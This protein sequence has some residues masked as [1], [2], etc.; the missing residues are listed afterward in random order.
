MEENNNKISSFQVGVIGFF[1][2]DAIFVGLG[3]PSMFSL[4]E[5]DAWI[6]SLLAFIIGIIPIVILMY[7]INYKPELNILEKNKVIFGKWV[8]SIVNILLCVYILFMAV[9]VLWNTTSFAISIYLVDTPSN[10]IAGMFV[11]AA[12]YAVI[13]GIETIGRTTEILFFM[14]VAII[15]TIVLS[16]YSHADMDN[17]KP[18]VAHGIMPVVKNTFIY[19]SY[20]FTPAIILTIIRKNSIVNKEH[21]RRYLIGGFILGLLLMVAVFVIIPAVI[22]PSLA[23]IYRF[24]AYYVQ[25]KISIGGAIN[26]VENFLSIHWLFSTFIMIVMGVYFLSEFVKNLFKVEKKKTM[27]LIIAGIG[28]LIVFLQNFIFKDSVVSLDFMKDTF[29]LY[30]GLSLFILMLLICFMIF[31]KRRHKK[32]A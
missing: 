13:R 5:Q 7:I 18:Y 9:L 31:I 10:V 28:V 29:P 27:M 1:L 24:P 14:A 21:Y 26:N 15:L 17:L 16:L 2:V 32:K 4:A 8:G 19:M 3:I 12:V 23:A 11:L 6:S 30:V 22:T 25:R 20:C